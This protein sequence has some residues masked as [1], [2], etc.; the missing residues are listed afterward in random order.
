MDDAEPIYAWA[1]SVFLEHDIYC[2]VPSGDK[3]SRVE[4]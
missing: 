3:K 2:M 1:S 4:Q